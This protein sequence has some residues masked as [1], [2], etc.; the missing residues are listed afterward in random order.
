MA[1]PAALISYPRFEDLDKANITFV[2]PF[3]RKKSRKLRCDKSERQL[4]DKNSVPKENCTV[5]HNFTCNREN[6]S[7]NL[8]RIKKKDVEIL[9]TLDEHEEKEQ[10]I[11]DRTAVDGLGK[12]V[13]FI[14]LNNC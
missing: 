1:N 7:T 11:Y 12:V 13:A 4:P 3:N 10:V 2:E 8:Q 14:I 5:E 9:P 6:S